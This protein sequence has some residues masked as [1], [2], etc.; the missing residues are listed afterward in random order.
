MSKA[1]PAQSITPGCEAGGSRPEE[2][3][4]LPLAQTP[5]S[6]F[7]VLHEEKAS[8]KR[9]EIVSSVENPVIFCDKAD[10]PPLFPSKQV[11]RKYI[12]SKL[13]LYK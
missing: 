6:P 2:G 1:H 13:S 7:H 10:L 12:P 3:I 5:M 11:P 8:R 4:T 9:K